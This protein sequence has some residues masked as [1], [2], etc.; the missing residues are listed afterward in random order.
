MLGGGG[1]WLS[2]GVPSTHRISG[3]SLAR[4]VHGE[5]VHVHWSSQS[6]IVMSW[7]LEF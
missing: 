4:H 5:V 6:G 3:L 7:G 2:M 1:G